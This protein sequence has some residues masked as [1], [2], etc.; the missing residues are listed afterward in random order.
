MIFQ[1][2]AA[3]AVILAGLGPAYS[4]GELPQDESVPVQTRLEHAWQNYR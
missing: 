2:A 3:A 4:Y 1:V